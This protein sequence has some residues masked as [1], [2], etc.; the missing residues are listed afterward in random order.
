MSDASSKPKALSRWEQ[1]KPT[2]FFGDTWRE[3]NARRIDSQEPDWTPFGILAFC[4]LILVL[5]NYFGQSS[6]LFEH[7][8]QWAQSDPYWA[9]VVQDET[10][11]SLYLK[12]WWGG[13]R[14]VGYIVLPALFIRLVLKGSIREHGFGFGKL[15]EHL[16]IYGLAASIVLVLV[17]IVSFF[18]SFQN[19]YPMFRHAGDSWRLLLLWEAVYALQFLGLEFFYRGFWVKSLEP[20]MGS[21]AIAA[22]MVPYCM[23]HFGKPW[24]ETVGAIAA[25]LALG[26]LA[27]KSRSIWPGFLVHVTVA[28]A[29]D[30]A[31]LLQT[32]GLPTEW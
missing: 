6:W 28:F 5:I 16:W 20:Y 10:R 15:K 26:T 7:A 22:M 3:S 29:M 17:G 1:L 14:F 2:H 9:E 19:K 21:M 4:S 12:L 8:R 13:W 30:A 31:A 27:L 11:F 24:P 25:G 18:P 23:I 32:G